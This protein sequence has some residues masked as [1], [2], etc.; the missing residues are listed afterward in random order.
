MALIKCKEC[1]KE[2]SKKAEACPHCGAKRKKGTSVFTWFILIMIILIYGVSQSGMESAKE[3]KVEK[4]DVMT[5]QI[6]AAKEKKLLAELK[7]LPA[8]DIYT[9]RDKYKE[10]F[11]LMDDKR[12]YVKKWQ[13]YKMKVKELEAKIG[14]SPAGGWDGVPFPIEKYVKNMAKDP[15]SVD[16]VGCSNQ[17]YSDAGWHSTCKFRAK[18]GFGA[19]TLEVWNFTI[20]HN[21]VFNARKI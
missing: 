17:T 1:N 19:L 16:F 11:D 8:I 5:P 3:K 6:R 10:L 20:R 2:I 12:K 4:L 21:A 18:N 7:I 14:K 15:D 13:H 9:N